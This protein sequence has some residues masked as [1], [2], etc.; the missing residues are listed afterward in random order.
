MQI[1]WIEIEKLKPNPKNPYHHSPEDIDEMVKILKYQGWR[2]PIIT[3]ESH[4]LWAG[5]KRLAAAQKMGLKK[6]P[7]HIQEFQSYEQAYAFMTSDN[8]LGKRSDVD[9][10]M[11]NIE[12]PSLGPDFDIDLLGIK[13]FVIEPA[14]VY[15]PEPK[16]DP[17]DKETDMMTCPNCGVL[18]ENG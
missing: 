3:D 5:H 17:K 7:I 10:G 4:L 14:D 1:E 11:V 15:D 9:L 16:G 2:H 13:D 18:I 8:E 12:I 6:V